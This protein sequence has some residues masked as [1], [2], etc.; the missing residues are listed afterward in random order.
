MNGRLTCSCSI[1]EVEQALMQEL[2]RED[3]AE[4][5]RLLTRESSVLSGFPTA[6]RLLHHLRDASSGEDQGDWSDEILGELLRTGQ[7]HCPELRQRL[8]PMSRLPANAAMA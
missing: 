7:S 8:V 4:Q 5:Y 2:A 3:T 1:C 6:L